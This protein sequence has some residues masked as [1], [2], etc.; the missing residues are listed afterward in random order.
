MRAGSNNI[1][2]DIV[3]CPKCDTKLKYEY[4]RYHHIGKAHCP[5]CDFGRERVNFEARD[6]DLKKQFF[7]INDSIYHINKKSQYTFLCT[8]IIILN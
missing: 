5:N 4:Y 6:V 8:G 2:K 1:V 7:T 3:V